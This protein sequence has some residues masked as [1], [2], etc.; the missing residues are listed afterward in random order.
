[1]LRKGLPSFLR[2]LAITEGWIPTGVYT[3][4]SG[5]GKTKE[6]EVSPLILL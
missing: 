6:K 1:L 4:E 5:C 2:K 3:H